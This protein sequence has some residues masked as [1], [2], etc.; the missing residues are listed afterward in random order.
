MQLGEITSAIFRTLDGEGVGR[1][2]IDSLTGLGTTTLG[3][4]ALGKAGLTQLGLARNPHNVVMFQGVGFR[5]HR[6]LYKLSPKSAQESIALFTMIRELKMAMAVG[7]DEGGTYFE[8][9]VDR[10]TF[11]YPDYFTID[12][13]TNNNGNNTYLHSI[14]PSMLESM[15]VQYHPNGIQS[16]AVPFDQPEAMPTPTEIELTLEFK[17]TEIVTKQKIQRDNR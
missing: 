17:E 1:G 12:Y 2:I 13:V 7:V 3:S 11:T 15:D 10:N 6:F 14:G 4:N 16:Y 8:G 9:S 5:T